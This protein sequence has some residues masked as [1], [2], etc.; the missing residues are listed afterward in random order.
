MLESVGAGVTC[1]CRAAEVSWALATFAVFFISMVFSENLWDSK[2]ITIPSLLVLHPHY[3]EPL[4]SHSVLPGGQVRWYSP[5][6]F[7]NEDME[8]Q[9]G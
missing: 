8:A 7:V 4:L 3:A 9:K 5:P 6:P 1:K 2:L